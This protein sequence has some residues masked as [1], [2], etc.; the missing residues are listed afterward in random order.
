LY[1][2]GAHFAKKVA[3]IEV[4][5]FCSTLAV[6]KTH[7]E[8]SKSMLINNRF[9][10]EKSFSCSCGFQGNRKWWAEVPGIY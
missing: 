4:L 9:W 3:P 10:G 6:E 5:E 8:V 7:S 1:L 2:C